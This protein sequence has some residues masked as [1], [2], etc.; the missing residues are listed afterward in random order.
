MFSYH[1]FSDALLSFVG[2]PNDAPVYAWQNSNMPSKI[3]QS[4]YSPTLTETKNNFTAFQAKLTLHFL[5][6]CIC[7]AKTSLLSGVIRSK[8]R[9]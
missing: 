4:V 5:H 7:D 2:L 9:M 8:K 3:G 6:F 1:S